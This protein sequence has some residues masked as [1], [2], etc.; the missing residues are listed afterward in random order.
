MK[1]LKYANLN[2]PRTEAERQEI[3]TNASYYYGQYMDALGIDWRNDPNSNDTPMRVAKAFVNDLAEGCYI[4]PPKIT[5]FKNVNKYDG[6]VFQGNIDV[7]SFCSHHHLPFVGYAHVAYLP[8]DNV[9]GLSKLN[10]IV[11]WFARRPQVQENLTMQ[12]HDYLNEVCDKNDGV[13]VVIEAKHMCACVRGVR[14]DSTMMTSKLSKAFKKD[15]A[16]RE[17]FYKFIENIKA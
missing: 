14:H 8:G 11:E 2:D 15:P 7:K 10:R 13:A 16:T 4:E 12:I 1:K 3:I 6:I 5:T 17:E 9:I